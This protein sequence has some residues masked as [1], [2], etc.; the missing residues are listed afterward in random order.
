MVVFF[1]KQKTAYEMRISDWSSDVCSSDLRKLF[2]VGER[3]IAC[4]KVIQC[5]AD[6]MRVQ[7]FERSLD[8]FRPASQEYCFRD[9]QFQKMRGHLGSMQIAQQTFSKIVLAEFSSSSVQGDMSD[10]NTCFEI[11]RA[12]CRERVGQYV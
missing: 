7:Q 5:D 8:I 4:A 1:F 2:E 6:T 11:G 3:S 12:S 10:V 9:F